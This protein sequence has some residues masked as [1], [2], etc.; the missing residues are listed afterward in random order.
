MLRRP[1]GE[2]VFTLDLSS[3][4]M[5]SNLIGGTNLGFGRL[6]CGACPCGEMVFTLDLGS[7]VMS[8]NL[9]GG[10]GGGGRRGR[11]GTAEWSEQV[12]R[13]SGYVRRCRRCSREFD[14]LSH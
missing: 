11:R 14:S 10:R 6:F 3:G 4:V 12:R 5:S 2:T 13:Q 1:R 8:S 7:R 9:V